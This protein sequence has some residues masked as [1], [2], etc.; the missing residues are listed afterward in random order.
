[1]S[2][3]ES[4]VAVVTGAA[5][6]IGKAT[7]ERMVAN[8][9]CVVAA[10]IQDEQGADLERAHPGKV[11]YQSCDVTDEAQLAAALDRAISEFGQLDILF[12]NAGAGG[13]P[14]DLDVLDMDSYHQTMNLLLTSVVMGTKQAVIRMKERGGAIV[15]TAS[16]AAF[17]SGYSPLVYAVA[18][19]GVL[20]FSKA[21]AAQLATH[22]IRINAVCPGMVAT[23]IFG[24]QLGLSQD[25]SEQVAAL[26][27]SEGGSVQPLNRTGQPRDIAEAVCYLASDEASF[28]T[29][30]HIM[31]DG[32]LS[33]GNPSSWA[34]G[35]STPI[36]KL[37]ESMGLDLDS[38]SRGGAAD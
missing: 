25:E 32:G 19:A 29:G 26:L 8:G 15:N 38:M 10:D 27:A 5:S 20:Q 36:S 28:V 3:L 4:K 1:M 12:N 17:G 31:V 21:S 9:A 13:T 23:A 22:N 34:E 37:A 35:N 6:G 14:L 18:K 7:V 11:V 33:S 24:R 2:K 16:I 30:T